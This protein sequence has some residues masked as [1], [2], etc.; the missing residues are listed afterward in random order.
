MGGGREFSSQ[1]LI[2]GHFVANRWGG[3]AAL[4]FFGGWLRRWIL[5]CEVPGQGLVR[6][7]I[8][9]FSSQLVDFPTFQD[10]DFSTFRLLILFSEFSRIL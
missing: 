10:S 3:L 6:V 7:L 5:R 2:A 1:G 8:P 4:G 9:G